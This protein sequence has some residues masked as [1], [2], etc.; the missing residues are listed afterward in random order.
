M[1]PIT[2]QRIARTRAGGAGVFPKGTTTRGNPRCVSSRRCE[3]DYALVPFDEP[4]RH[5]LTRANDVAH[6]LMALG[7]ETK[8][9]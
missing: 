8:A 6:P 2:S 7:P 4:T 9:G 1:A 3:A 5:C